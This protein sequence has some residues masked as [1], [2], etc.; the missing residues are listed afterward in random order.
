[1]QQQ[2]DGSCRSST[3]PRVDICYPLGILAKHMS[4]P[5]PAH[6]KALHQHLRYLQGTKAFGLTY[7][8]Q[9]SFEVSGYCDASYKQCQ[10]LAKSITGWVTTVGGT[11]LS[12]KSQKQS[13]TAQSTTKAEYIAACSIN[14]ECFYLKQLLKE[15]GYDITITVYCDSTSALAMI[16]NPV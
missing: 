10:F 9:G 16:R 5:G 4:N 8:G 15:I 6:I 2:C 13:T 14:K 12:W 7:V 1:M 3:F 11:A